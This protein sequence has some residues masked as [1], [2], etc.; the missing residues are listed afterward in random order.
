VTGALGA[1]YAVP[2]G[3]RLSSTVGIT[4]AFYSF[5]LRDSSGTS[6]E[7]GPQADLLVHFGVSWGWP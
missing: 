5:D 6:L 4:T 7:R 2:I 1:G 3:H